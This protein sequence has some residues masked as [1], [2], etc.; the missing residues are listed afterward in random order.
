MFKFVSDLLA[1][2]CGLTSNILRLSST[3]ARID[4]ELRDALPM[5][6]PPQVALPLPEPEEKGPRPEEI[7]HT[8]NGVVPKPRPPKKGK[9]VAP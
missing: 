7:D 2:V 8:A 3:V 5:R 9:E 4:S 1:A 6:H